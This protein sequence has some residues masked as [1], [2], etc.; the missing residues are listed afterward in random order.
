VRVEAGRVVSVEHR[1]LDA[2]RWAAC[3]VDAAGAASGSDVVDLVR[4]ALAREVLAAEGR[5][6][7][8]RV[9][10]RGAARAHVEMEREP[11][12]WTSEIRAVATDVEGEG[13]WVEKVLFETRAPID[14]EELRE[15]DDAIGQVARALAELSRSDEAVAPLLEELAEL[16]KKLPH[17][18]RDSGEKTP[19]DDATA[20]RA[21]MG[22]VEQMLLPRLLYGGE[23]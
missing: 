7:A 2:V 12:R 1:A 4:E 22:D 15:R 16:R 9:T 18:L 8:A 3:S 5:P 21:V 17:E 23:R 20:L 19:L 13:V 10:I 14:L 6:L 11:E